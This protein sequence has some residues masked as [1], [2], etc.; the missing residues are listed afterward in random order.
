MQSQS[1]SG[2]TLEQTACNENVTSSSAQVQNFRI[3]MSRSSKQQSPISSVLPVS[4]DNTCGGRS[5]AT[6]GSPT[7]DDRSSYFEDQHRTD[8][9]FRTME[10]QTTEQ[11]L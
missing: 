11:R 4:S 6:P 7:I 10:E 1:K 5:P 3:V 8:N 2:L 9:Q